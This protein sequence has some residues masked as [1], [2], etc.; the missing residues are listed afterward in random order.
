[1][2]DG[3]EEATSP[4]DRKFAGWGSLEEMEGSPISRRG[5]TM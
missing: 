2:I 1:M 3:A 5:A 4:E